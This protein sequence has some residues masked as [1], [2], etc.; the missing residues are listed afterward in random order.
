SRRARAAAAIGVLAPAVRFFTLRLGRGR[1]VRRRGR[2]RWRL[3]TRATAA[4]HPPA[5]SGQTGRSTER[6]QAAPAAR[7]F[8]VA[9]PREGPYRK[10]T[11]LGPAPRPGPRAWRQA[12]RTRVENA[13]DI[14]ESFL[15]SSPTKKSGPATASWQ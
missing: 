3:H 15:E 10:N 12:G 6:S 13:D 4:T 1:H 9:E 11:R 2:C 7:L 14:S 8:T 5:P